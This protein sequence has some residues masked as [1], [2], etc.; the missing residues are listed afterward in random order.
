MKNPVKGLTK[1]NAGTVGSVAV[2]LALFG[3]VIY[4]IR[5]APSNAVTDVAKKAANVVA[6]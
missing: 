1:I 5:K 6:A 2:G 4:A 3:V